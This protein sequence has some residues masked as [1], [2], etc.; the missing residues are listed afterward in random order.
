MDTSTFGMIIGVNRL[1]ER[2][3]TDAILDDNQKIA[4]EFLKHIQIF[5]LIAIDKQHYPLAAI[6]VEEICLILS[7]NQ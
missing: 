4:F 6:G 3:Y 1:P 2:S 7:F 5:R